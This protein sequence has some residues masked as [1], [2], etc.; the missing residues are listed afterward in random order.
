MRIVK[1]K[2]FLTLPSGTVYQKYDDLSAAGELHVKRETCGNDWI[3]TAIDGH[4]LAE[5]PSG[6][7]CTYAMY[8]WERGEDLGIDIERCY[9]DGLFEKEDEM[10]FLVWSK[11]DVSRL[12]KL[13]EVANG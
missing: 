12:I 10:S 6:S 13:L 11:E 7:D 2:E 5:V 1:R 9:R 3:C 4:H 8:S